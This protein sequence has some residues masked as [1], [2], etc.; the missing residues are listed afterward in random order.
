MFYFFLFFLC[1]NPD[2]LRIKQRLNV[3]YN[4][5]PQISS[6][7][8]T[9][10]LQTFSVDRVRRMRL[11][12]WAAAATATSNVNGSGSDVLTV[13]EMLESTT[14]VIW[15]DAFFG[16]ER[17]KLWQNWDMMLFWLEL[18]QARDDERVGCSREWWEGRG[19]RGGFVQR[20]NFYALLVLCF[21]CS[22]A[23]LLKDVRHRTSNL[24]VLKNKFG[25]LLE[26]QGGALVTLLFFI[27]QVFYEARMTTVVVEL[28]S[29]SMVMT[30]GVSRGS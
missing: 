30:N 29:S 19:G 23:S 16:S 11:Q 13:T 7:R 25:V 12:S 17:A 6:L 9:I 27:S 20:T 21:F 8:K 26:F 18:L 28:Q 1:F 24:I 10:L 5:L 3:L 4:F 14:R 2:L 22:L 15:G